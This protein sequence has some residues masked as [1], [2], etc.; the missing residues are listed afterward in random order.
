M[1]NFTSMILLLV[2][3][4]VGCTQSIENKDFS[5]LLGD[6]QRTNNEAGQLTTESWEFSQKEYQGLGV[7]VVGSDTVFFENIS[8]T[9]IENQM[10][11]VVETPEHGDPVQFKITSQTNESFTAE[12]PENDFPKKIIYKKTK[13]GLL[14]TVSNDERTIDFTFIPA[15]N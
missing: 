5:W 4:S 11:L 1:K 7:T 2:I 9:N 10:F 6:W 12:N 3:T 14:A 13:E 15:K 8:L